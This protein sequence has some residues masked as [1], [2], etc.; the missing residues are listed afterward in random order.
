[1]TK[2]NEKDK[3]DHDKFAD[4]LLDHPE[5][6]KEVEKELIKEEKR[7]IEQ[8]GVTEEP[9]SMAFKVQDLDTMKKLVRVP[10]YC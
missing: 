5:E 4:E 1:M 8:N 3:A 7:E 9:S 2:E 6:E 10:K